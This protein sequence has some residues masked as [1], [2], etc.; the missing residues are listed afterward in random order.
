MKKKVRGKND[1]SKHN[2][3][4]KEKKLI[5][6]IKNDVEKTKLRLMFDEKFFKR[7]KRITKEFKSEARKLK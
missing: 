7:I 2:S 6:K 1:Y 3:D 4:K 5:I